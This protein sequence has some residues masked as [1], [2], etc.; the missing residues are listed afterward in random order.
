MGVV[1]AYEDALICWGSVAARIVDEQ[2]VPVSVVQV[3]R[4]V[5]G[6]VGVGGDV[7]L[8]VVAEGVPGPCDRV[9]VGVVAVSAGRVGPVWADRGRGG[10]CV[11]LSGARGRV[12][13]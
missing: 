2:L 7:T 11:G 8:G 10:R 5:V 4:L 12:G 13:G 1:A 6:L 3:A 9:A